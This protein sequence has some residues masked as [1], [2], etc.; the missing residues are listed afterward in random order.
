MSKYVVTLHRS[1][2]IE[3]KDEESAVDNAFDELR[4]DVLHLSIN[5]GEFAYD[6][7][8]EGFHTQEWREG[9]WE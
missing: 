3:A 6:C 9:D 2:V 4:K 1:Y 8:E 5:C 7:E